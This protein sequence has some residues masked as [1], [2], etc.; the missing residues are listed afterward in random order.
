AMSVLCRLPNNQKEYLFGRFE[1]DLNNLDHYLIWNGYLIIYN[2][3]YL[4]TETLISK[5]YTSIPSQIETGHVPKFHKNMSPCKEYNHLIFQK[6]ILPY[7]IG[8][9]SVS[10]KNL[11]DHLQILSMERL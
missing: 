3:Q 9:L 8:S 7:K 10:T 5:K 11:G 1:K 2:S 6:D 4:F